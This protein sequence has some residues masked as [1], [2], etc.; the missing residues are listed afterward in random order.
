MAQLV[1][2]LPQRPVAIKV[3]NE[4][5]FRLKDVQGDGNCF[6]NAVVM[7]HEINIECPLDLKDQMAAELMNNKEAKAIYNEMF[8]SEKEYE[9]FVKGIA[10]RG[11]YQGTKAA[12]F[13]CFMF[14][15]NIC[16]ITNA[17]NGFEIHNTQQWLRL[18]QANMVIE[19]SAP[20]IYLYHH[21]FKR[22]FKKSKKCNHFG[23]L[24][25]IEASR[26]SDVIYENDSMP[27]EESAPIE[28][29]SEDENTEVRVEEIR[30]ST[31]GDSKSEEDL[32]EPPLKRCK[33]KDGQ[34]GKQK[35]MNEMK[36]KKMMHFLGKMK[37]NKQQA[38]QIEAQRKSV[39]KLDIELEC[40]LSIE[41]II[42]CLESEETNRNRK[43]V[44]SLKKGRHEL[45]W[46][47]RSAIIYFYLHPALGKKDL[48]RSSTLFRV[49][50]RTLEG[51]VTKADMKRKWPSM[52][53][54]LKF[55]DV[56]QAMPESCTKQRLLN[57]DIDESVKKLKTIPSTGLKIFT[58]NSSSKF[59]HQA[60]F[61]MAKNNQALY[62]RRTDK[63]IIERQAR[64]RK[65]MEVQ[66]FIQETV[67]TRW[68]MGMP[69]PK[70]ELRRLVVAKSKEQSWEE[71][72]ETYGQG[73]YE[74][75]R[76][77]TVY[78]DR[79]IAKMGY[80]VRKTTVSQKIPEDWRRLA[81]IGAKRVRES[82]RQANV[83]V[84]LA[85]DETF[86]RS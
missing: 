36:Q 29:N 15:V 21:L 13:V 46:T 73:T 55:D 69:I 38:E 68:N 85:A 86:I 58:R 63:R 16:L 77:L 59:S 57:L 51:W 40:A 71:W 12:L 78:L 3:K 7:S 43:S 45:D 27:H 70:E 79:A 22:P 30:N 23:Y 75:R 32:L 2:S 62:V 80:S 47:S 64:T 20:T 56:I 41:R 76:K 37:A 26:E 18:M 14:E 34:I 60:I 24:H 67:A 72:K 1:E 35:N 39:N 81:E 28:I 83:D 9:T 10:R 66:N 53:N 33:T 25:R 6:F 31:V 42:S 74:T 17:P 52:V 50:P 61:A 44:P 11:K 4:G 5:L 19:D 65:Y 8:P 84:V 82:F 49:C 54:D 48:V